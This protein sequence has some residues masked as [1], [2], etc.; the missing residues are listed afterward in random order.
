[1][2]G[3]HGKAGSRH[4]V[5]ALRA[6]ACALALLAAVPGGAREIRARKPMKPV[7]PAVA[8]DLKVVHPSNRVAIACDECIDVKAPSWLASL[9]TALD[10]R[11]LEL[12]PIR[13]ATA[14]Q[15]TAGQK[16]TFVA[17]LRNPSGLPPTDATRTAP[18]QAPKAMAF[19]PPPVIPVAVPVGADAVP[20]TLDALDAALGAR[21]GAPGPARF[22][23]VTSEAAD[24]DHILRAQA[25]WV[26]HYGKLDAEFVDASELARLPARSY[27]RYAAIGFLV[28]TLPRAGATRTLRF[29][30]DYVQRGGGV[31]ALAGVPDTDLDDLFGVVR[32]AG[33]DVRV[34]SYTCDARF[35][36]GAAGFDFATDSDSPEMVD[37]VTAAE[38]A[39]VL[40][41]G[42]TA[43]GTVPLAISRARG[44]GHTLAW[45]GGWLADKS[46]RGM[47]LLSMMEVAAPSA[48]A[49]LGLR[50][51]FV[52]DCP[53][54]MWNRPPEG[55]GPEVKT[56]DADFY[57][58]TWWPAMTMFFQRHSL[59]PTFAMMLTYDD[60]V[61]GDFAGTGFGADDPH[62]VEL[63]KRVA[64][65]PG[66]EIGLH[67]YNHQP[68]VVS[69]GVPGVPVIERTALWPGRP[70]MEAGL[71]RVAAEMERLL[72]PGRVPWAYVAPNNLVQ[73]LGKEAVHGVYPDLRSI[74]TEYLDENDTLGQE[75]GPDPDVPT[76]ID[77]PRVSSEHFI[78]NDSAREI[79]D[80]LAAPGIFAHFVHPDD[81]FDPQRAMGHTFEEMMKSLD[82]LVTRVDTAYPF[83]KARTASE[84]AADIRSFDRARL[85]ATRGPKGLLLRAVDP[86]P[87][88]LLVFVRTPRGAG[89]RIGSSCETVSSI[90]ADGRHYL[91]IGNTACSITW[92]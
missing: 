45:N 32:A 14:D 30:N 40:C 9:G 90:P 77:V 73:K 16:S 78:D 50:V 5:S 37:P 82:D 62:A 34:T 41:T 61:Q 42:R 55:A 35:L 53:M 64:A 52:D 21:S 84:A 83:L 20:A 87:F 57:L 15:I 79:F 74:S 60:E 12:V 18:P 36:P 25:S 11:G 24:V 46:A 70:E 7:R 2:T 6:V 71:R 4:C 85:E 22:L 88:G 67:G 3:T 33:D 76:V 8:N 26:V 80:A 27:D 51:F 75:Y 91:R 1:M 59:R 44:A 86:P 47:I 19:P 66:A 39:S 10:A 68:L 89:V 63:L 72:G 28:S 43:N 58:K 38:G 49:M 13:T 65:T 29:L 23:F 81:I 56:T 17:I 48:A 92:D 69:R 54:P 31:A